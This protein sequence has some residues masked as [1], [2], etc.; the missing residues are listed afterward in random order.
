MDSDFGF[1][2]DRE[3]R[4]KKMEKKAK[5]PLHHEEQLLRVYHQTIFVLIKPFLIFLVGILLPTIPLI[6]YDLFRQYRGLV[7]LLFIGFF[8]YLLKHIII[9]QLNS[10]IITTARL[11]KVSH[12]GLFKKLVVETPLDRIL[13]V[14]YKTTGVLSS[15][16]EFGDVEVQVVGLI[17]PMNLRYINS[18]AAI[19]DYLWKAHAE[20]AGSKSNLSAEKIPHLQEEIGYTKE[21][22]RVI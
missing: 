21:N 14:S 9:W 4:T 19:K 5:V 8:A 1:F 22:Q 12:E 13:N 2:P 6:R 18:P 11:I 15:L 10:Y 16:F 20:F 7:L 3:K 17:E